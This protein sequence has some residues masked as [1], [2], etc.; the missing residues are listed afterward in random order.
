MKRAVVAA[1]AV[2]ACGGDGWLVSSKMLF[3]GYDETNM[4]CRTGPCVHDENTDLTVFGGA[5]YLVHRTAE[6]QIL[7]PNS[8]LRV[9]RSMDHGAHWDLQAVIAAPSDRDLRDPSFYVDAA[10]ELSIKAITRLAVTSARDSNVDSITIR[11]HSADGGMTWSALEPIGPETWSFWRVKADTDGTLYSAAYEDGDKSV[12]LFSSPDGVTWT[13][14]AT[15]YAVSDDTPLETELMFDGGGLTAYVRMDGTND[16]ILGN[17]GR[18][19]TKL[20][21]AQRPYSTF[22]CSQELDGVRLDGPVAWTYEGR[23]FMVARKHLMEARD[24]KR[25]A[26]YELSGTTWIEHGE[27]PSAGDTSYAGVAPIA[28]GKF[29]VTYYSSNL[30]ED[31][32]WS[33]GMLGPTDIWQATIDL[34]AL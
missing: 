31:P 17:S 12:V 29:L 32:P 16:E 19:R 10:G 24:R 33:L 26:L 4:D 30:H 25:T 14:G 21:T 5:T 20:C 13:K 27:F 18:L 2:G 3:D 8:S 23:T 7:G 1:I 6:S 22:D 15:M 9:Y 11:T 28:G 34:S